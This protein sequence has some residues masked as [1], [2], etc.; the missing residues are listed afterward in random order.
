M[1]NKFALT[2]LGSIHYFLGIEVTKSGSNYALC[3]SKYLKE[4]LEKT[5]MSSCHPCSTPMTPATR[6]SKEGGESFSDPSLYR[7]T[8]GALQYLTHTR[9]DIAFA[10]PIMPAV[11]MI[12][13]PLEGTVSIMETISLPG[14]PKSNTWY[15]EAARNLNIVL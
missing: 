12:G 11:L 8:I 10:M 9:P 5:N 6:L 4:L 14:A 3:Q 7:S 1:N 2:Y 13:A 15:P